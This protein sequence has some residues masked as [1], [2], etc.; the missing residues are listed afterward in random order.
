MSN[1]PTQSSPSLGPRFIKARNTGLQQLPPTCLFPTE[2]SSLF[3]GGGS[4]I[5]R[6]S[7]AGGTL[8]QV[9]IWK[10]HIYSEVKSRQSVPVK[11]YAFYN[12][13]LLLVAAGE[14][15]KCLAVA[16]VI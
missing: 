10:P 16:K 11:T 2:V 4:P 8:N 14:S 1:M 15:K 12:L 13:I 3:G 6:N 5:L 7:S 9:P